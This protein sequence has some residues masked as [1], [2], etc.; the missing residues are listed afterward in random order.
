MGTIYPRYDHCLGYPGISDKDCYFAVIVGATQVGY[1]LENFVFRKII[2]LF[3][4]LEEH[5]ATELKDSYFHVHIWPP[6][7]KKRG[8][9]Q[10]NEYWWKH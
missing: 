1:H 2:A 6:N 8:K 9:L 10:E 4:L 7:G 3:Y 5:G